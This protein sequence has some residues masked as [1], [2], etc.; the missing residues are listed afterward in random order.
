MRD[1]HEKKEKWEEWEER[2]L[3][4]MRNKNGTREVGGEKEVRSWWRKRS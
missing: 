3:A 1:W 2:K 4:G